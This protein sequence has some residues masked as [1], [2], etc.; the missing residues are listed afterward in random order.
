MSPFAQF[1]PTLKCSKLIQGQ[2]Y[3]TSNENISLLT[4]RKILKLQEMLRERCVL[5]LTTVALLL[6]SVRIKGL[7]L[8]KDI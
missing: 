2:N 6:N 8:R 7:K 1:L 3:I 5:L 4:E